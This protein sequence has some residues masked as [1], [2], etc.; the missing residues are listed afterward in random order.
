MVALASFVNAQKEGPTKGEPVFTDE[1][2]EIASQ[3]GKVS[4]GKVYS[5]TAQYVNS[6][7]SKGYS[8]KQLLSATRYN[9]N[10][11]GNKVGLIDFPGCECKSPVVLSNYDFENL[12]ANQ[13]FTSV[14]ASYTA[15]GIS[16]TN[17][18]GPGGGV[19]S[20][21]AGSNFGCFGGFGSTAAGDGTGSIG[22]TISNN[23]ISE[24]AYC[25]NNMSFDFYAESRGE[26]LFGPT[27]FYVEILDGSGSLVFVSE[28]VSTAGTSSSNVGSFSFTGPGAA[29]GDLVDTSLDWL[30]FGAGDSLT[31]NIVG[32]GAEQLGL[33][34]DNVM[35]EACLV[36]E[37]S[38]SLLI[39]LGSSIMILRRKK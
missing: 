15:P 30:E 29:Q 38:S 7:D 2:K 26:R 20:N 21:A 17:I 22:F 25:L 24:A 11:S 9:I 5:N 39:L 12:S 14:P 37:P 3:I 32:S 4:R 27:S 8:T 31:F 6:K 33:D 16:A 34:I 23:N 13:T 19:I 1:D 36:P 18:A 10:Q 28:I 35:V